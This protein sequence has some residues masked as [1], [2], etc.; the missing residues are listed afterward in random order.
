[1]LFNEYEPDSSFDKLADCELCYR[2]KVI[3]R[4]INY[5]LSYHKY[6]DCS[7]HSAFYALRT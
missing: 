7:T 2:N 4:D 6:M 1:M 3:V 5:V